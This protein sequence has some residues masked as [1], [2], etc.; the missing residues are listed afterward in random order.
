MK[1][2]IIVSVIM[3]VYKPN[4]DLFYKSVNSILNQ[5]F[6]NFEMIIVDDGNNYK[7]RSFISK[8]C[9]DKRI[10]ILHNKYNQGLTKSLNLALA[11]C[12]G[13]Y[14]ARQDADD[15]SNHDR[16]FKQV[17]FLNENN[18][19]G[20]LGTN[21]YTKFD[22]KKMKQYNIGNRPLRVQMMYKNP[23]CHS[24]MMIRKR[25]IL[26]LGGYNEKFI[27]SQDFELWLR[28][29]RVTEG[30]VL[31]DILITRHEFSRVSMS[32]SIVPSLDQLKNG[33]KLRFKYILDEKD[34]TLIPFYL[35]GTLFATLI[36][37]YKIKDNL[38]RIF[39]N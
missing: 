10:I 32:S 15:I 11:K 28:M 4:Y 7:D 6:T 39:K 18:E 29:F 38:L 1:N 24:S 12:N 25:I 17:K 20:F 14:I 34:I 37:L 8:V 27:R 30:F 36:F 26:N 13:K 21:F 16:L 9:V 31:P 2:K 3:G 23:F 22:N 19:F 35:I 33:I 5:T